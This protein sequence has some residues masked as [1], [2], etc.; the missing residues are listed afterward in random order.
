M[1]SKSTRPAAQYCTIVRSTVSQ[2]ANLRL[3]PLLYLTGMRERLV[4]HLDST[5]VASDRVSDPRRVSVLNKTPTG[6]VTGSYRDGDAD[7]MGATSF[8]APF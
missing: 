5:R 8:V 3:R 7:E 1:Y 2:P 4:S 6:E